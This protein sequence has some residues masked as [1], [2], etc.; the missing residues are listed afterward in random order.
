MLIAIVADTS[1]LSLPGG[2]E[3]LAGLTF[4]RQFARWGAERRAKG[5]QFSLSDDV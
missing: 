2:V 3:G 1:S 4:L 5:W